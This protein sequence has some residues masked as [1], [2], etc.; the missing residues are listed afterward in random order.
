VTFAPIGSSFATCSY[1]RT[2]RVWSVA[3]LQ[4]TRVMLG[5]L[6]DVRCCCFH[7]NLSMIA[8][9]SDD[10]SIR[11]WDIRDAKCVRILSRNG[12]SAAVCTIAIANDG[13]LLASGGEDGAALLWRLSTG[14]LLQ[15]FRVHTAPVWTV[16]FSQESAQLVTGS[17][18]CSVGV[19]DVGT[20]VADEAATDGG[21]GETWLISRLYTRDTPLLAVR[22]SRTNLIMAAGAYCP[23]DNSA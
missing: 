16:G 7:P 15:R 17:A 12:H 2:L 20:A 1:D 3:Q 22:Y 11:V 23:R 18:D 13:D 4:P 8:S 10:L 6:A 5:H 9:G 21:R 14:A 19:W